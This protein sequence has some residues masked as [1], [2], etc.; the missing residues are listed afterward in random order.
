MNKAR[1][2]NYSIGC[3]Q[4]EQ[5]PA[6]M[7]ATQLK[8]TIIDHLT[9]PRM[10]MLKQMNV[11]G[12]PLRLRFDATYPACPD[13][14]DSKVCAWLTDHNDFQELSEKPTQH[15][16]DA[17]LYCIDYIE[18]LAN[19]DSHNISRCACPHCVWYRDAK[20]LSRQISLQMRAADHWA[21]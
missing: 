5:K 15:L 14:D 2:I 17:M 7:G 13:C 9:Y 3:N 4:I 18:S 6:T 8:R 19:I 1:Y 16:F 20:F 11:E 10:V 12:C 21:S